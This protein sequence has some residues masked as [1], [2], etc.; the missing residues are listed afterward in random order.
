MFTET[1]IDF[2]CFC[3]YLRRDKLSNIKKI[4]IPLDK[5]WHKNKIGS[6]RQPSKIRIAPD[7]IPAEEKKRSYYRDRLSQFEIPPLRTKHGNFLPF[8]SY[9]FVYYQ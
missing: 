2:I 9:N 6:K 3:I 4:A 7:K 1:D 8:C 5:I